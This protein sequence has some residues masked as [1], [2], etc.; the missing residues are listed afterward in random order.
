MLFVVLLGGPGSGKGTQARLLQEALNIPQIA[1]GHLF[2]EHIK[3][4][5]QLGKLANTYIDAGDLVPDDVTIKMVHE[6][7][8]RPDCA[9][10]ALLDGYPRTIIQAEALDE[11]VAER[12]SQIAIVP[13]IEVEPE[14]LLRRLSGRWTCTTCGH[15]FHQEF[16]PPKVQGICDFD[17]SPLYQ[18]ED[19]TVETQRRRIVVYFELTAPLLGYY[20]ERG[21]FIDI[22][23]DQTIEEVQKDLLDTIKLANKL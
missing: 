19:D 22:N 14:V 1:S 9:N 15:V 5:T 17:G 7:I 2:R 20:K 10:G 4:E 8:S 12:G 13:C 6:R 11:F 3:N 18:R 21:I 23:G 16:S